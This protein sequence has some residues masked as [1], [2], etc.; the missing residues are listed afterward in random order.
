M[1]WLVIWAAAA[2]SEARALLDNNPAHRA[3]LDAAFGEMAAALQD[4]PL[5]A[6]ESQ[7]ADRRVSFYGP[8]GVWFRV[9][10]AARRVYILNVYAHSRLR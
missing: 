7:D 6:G 9:D 3:V 8:L 2:F 1:N 4:D 5:D 10:P